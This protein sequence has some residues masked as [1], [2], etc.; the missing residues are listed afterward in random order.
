MKTLNFFDIEIFS[1]DNIGNVCFTPLILFFIFILLMETVKIP[2]SSL[3]NEED[4][5]V[6]RPK[7]V[8]SMDV[9][10]RS[11]PS[12]NKLFVYDRNGIAGVN[13]TALFAG[14]NY[15]FINIGGVQG[16]LISKS[17]RLGHG[18]VGTNAKITALYPAVTALESRG[19]V[20]LSKGAPIQRNHTQSSFSLVVLE[21]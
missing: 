7:S 18:N 4:T 2:I 15:D 13:L 9:V 6:K 14:K 10:Y 16:Y 20:I 1:L 12:T 21:E 8:D 19:T 17:G 5:K 3:L 11:D